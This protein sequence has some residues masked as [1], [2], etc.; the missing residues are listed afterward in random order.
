MEETGDRDGP[1]SWDRADENRECERPAAGVSWDVAAAFASWAGA[2]LPFEHEWECA[3]R[4]VERRLYPWGNDHL[5]LGP[6]ILRDHYPVVPIASTTRTREGLE[7]ALVCEEWCADLWT[8]PCDAAAHRWG[9]VLR[10][11]ATFDGAVPSGAH[12]R[13]GDPYSLTQELTSI[14]LVRGDARAMPA[15][16]SSAPPE[17]RAMSRVRE[18]E[19]RILRPTLLALSSSPLS[20]E[21]RLTI[22]ASGWLRDV[23]GAGKLALAAMGELD[24]VR[25]GI[26]SAEG[27]WAWGLFLAAASRETVRRVPREHGI[28]LYN[29]HYRL[30]AD[31]RVRARPI[32]VF[33]MAFDRDR[34]RF[35]NRFVATDRD[36]A[37]DD[38]TP[39]MIR[40]SVLDAF[41]YYELHADSDED[42]F[43]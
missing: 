28:F 25:A 23:P 30:A 14:R 35:E 5:P 43:R 33:R 9:R 6:K 8:D 17:R 10:G 21:H 41:Q 42:P 24:G 27:Q 34:H 26:P 37:L 3:V 1:R 2:R 32:V 36:T 12:R 20:R 13:F 18:F 16:H 31:G 39:D 29:V 4:G 19:S 38:V 7:G 22:D 15:E 11:G 40:A